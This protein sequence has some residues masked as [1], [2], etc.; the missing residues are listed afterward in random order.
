M[1]QNSV[2]IK[3]LPLGTKVLKFNHSIERTKTPTI[4]QHT[5]KIYLFKFLIVCSGI[6]INFIILQW[7]I[8]DCVD[9]HFSLTHEYT[10][11]S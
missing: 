9:Y 6:P 8:M 1:E 5:L 3:S 7:H 11:Y 10:V 2:L 4:I